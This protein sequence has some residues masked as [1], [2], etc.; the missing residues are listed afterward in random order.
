MKSKAKLKKE[1]KEPTQ[2]DAKLELLS[3]APRRSPERSARGQSFN[4]G[5]I[6]MTEMEE[7][8]KEESME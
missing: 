4:R 1:R 7:E 5:S 3:N 8:K 6:S 2:H